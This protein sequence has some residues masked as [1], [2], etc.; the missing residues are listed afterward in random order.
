MSLQYLQ[1]SS[2]TRRWYT[3]RVYLLSVNRRNSSVVD[4]KRWQTRLSVDYVIVKDKKNA[5]DFLSTF[6]IKEY[7]FSGGGVIRDADQTLGIFDCGCDT[8]S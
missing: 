6:N 1:V 2:K 8:L 5:A 4:G 7:R 3:G